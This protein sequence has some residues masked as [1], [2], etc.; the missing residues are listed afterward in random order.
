ML[1]PNCLL[2]TPLPTTPSPTEKHL[3]EEI[4][5][6]MRNRNQQFSILKTKYRCKLECL[7]RDTVRFIRTSRSTLKL[8]QSVENFSLLIYIFI[9]TLC[10]HIAANSTNF[11]FSLAVDEI[12]RRTREQQEDTNFQLSL[13][14]IL[15]GPFSA[16]PAEYNSHIRRHLCTATEIHQHNEKSVNAKER[17]RA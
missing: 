10:Q 7:I 14:Q 2:P 4:T 1:L 11:L 3:R 6:T 13:T 12:A 15:L 9:E 16:A 5:F 8:T 17:E